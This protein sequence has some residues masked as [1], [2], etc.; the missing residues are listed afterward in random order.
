[1]KQT[2]LEQNKNPFTYGVPRPQKLAECHPRC[3][4]D[5]FWVRLEK[6][7]R[8]CRV[9]TAL[10]RQPV[11]WNGKCYFYGLEAFPE[12]ERKVEAAPTGNDDTWDSGTEIEPVEH[13]EIR[14][15]SSQGRL[16]QA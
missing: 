14:A 16:I 3:P 10:S 15:L 13:P 9:Y 2:A 6:G 4:G 5:C 12:P 11:A 1:M 7:I 8:R